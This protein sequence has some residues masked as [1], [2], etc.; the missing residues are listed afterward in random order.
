MTRTAPQ[1]RTRNDAEDWA[2][3]AETPSGTRRIHPCRTREA[4]QVAPL[5]PT[6]TTTWQQAGAMAIRAATRPHQCSPVSVVHGVLRWQEA[7][8]VSHLKAALLRVRGAPCL[9]CQSSC[10]PSADL[11]GVQWISVD[12]SGRPGVRP[13]P[14]WPRCAPVA[15]RAA[16]GARRS[17][18]ASAGRTARHSCDR[19]QE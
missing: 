5:A 12:F 7:V 3:T 9:P 8:P 14:P 19:R 16:D 11:S 1:R 2:D 18:R 13:E 17:R 4:R 15:R 10:R 6:T